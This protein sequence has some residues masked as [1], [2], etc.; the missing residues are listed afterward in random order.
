MSTRP[1]QLLYELLGAS[2]KRDAKAAQGA[3]Q[4]ASRR[5]RWLAQHR[6]T[7]PRPG[8]QHGESIRHAGHKRLAAST[9]TLGD[10]RTSPAG[11]CAATCGAKLSRHMTATTGQASGGDPPF[12]QP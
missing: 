6:S 11:L 8:R 9:T 2:R 10:A 7:S 4:P 1:L 12:A 5:Q 3:S